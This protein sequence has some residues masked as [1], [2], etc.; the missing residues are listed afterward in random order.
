MKLLALGINHKTAPVAV[1]ERAIFTSESTPA[2]LQDL[3]QNNAVNEAVILSTCNR[4]E[5]YTHT[6]DPHLVVDWF[7]KM[8]GPGS[9]PY[10]YKD[11]EAVQHIMRVASGLDSMVLGEPQILGQLK[12]AVWVAEQTGAVGTTLKRLFSSV[13]SVTKQVRTDTKIGANP[14]SIAYAIV[15]LAKRIFADI[16]SC[17]V[18]L[19]GAGNTIELVAT[20]LHSQ[21]IKRLTI[22]NRS[23]DKAEK[24]AQHYQASV[25]AMND[26]GRHLKK[27]DIIITATTSQLP[28]LGKGAVESALQ[29]RKHRIMLMVDLAVPRNIEP[30]IS[31]LE[32]VYLYNLDDLQTLLQEN[33][34][35]REAAAKQAEALIAAQAAHFMRELHALK[36]IDVVRAYRN[37]IEMLAEKELTRALQEIQK[38]KNVQE[39]LT[40]LTH[41]LIQKIMHTPSIE[42]RK[43]AYDG[44]LELLL[45]AK[46]L[47]DLS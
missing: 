27:A 3:L 42:L 12:Q 46:R 20:H 47:F 14:I 4:T 29:Q 16:P 39:V 19:I 26:V 9:D 36:S 22:A 11:Q 21:G 41:G 5:I 30:E 33:L 35:S 23:L 45:L 38:G 40:V 18:L 10:Q 6:I 32:D 2:A 13:F 31:G 24:L 25:I 37:K 44:Q 7:S 43:A 17:S 28:F 1:R 8:S 34:K 15:S